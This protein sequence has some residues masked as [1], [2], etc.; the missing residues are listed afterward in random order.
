MRRDA[1]GLPCTRFTTSAA[2]GGA[3]IRPCTGAPF[4]TDGGTTRLVSA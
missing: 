2:V 3:T 1:T 4:F